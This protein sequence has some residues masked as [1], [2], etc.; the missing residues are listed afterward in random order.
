[1]LICGAVKDFTNAIKTFIKLIVAKWF[2][3][4]IYINIFVEILSWRR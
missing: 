2:Y 4:N 1:M 3:I